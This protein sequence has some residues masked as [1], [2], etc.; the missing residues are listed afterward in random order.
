MTLA[1]AAT[2]SRSSPAAAARCALIISR[3]EGAGWPR[4][5]PRSGR[6]ASGNSPT[7]TCCGAWS[8][9]TPY[10]TARST[11]SRVRIS[12]A[13]GP[14]VRGSGVDEASA[15]MVD[16]A[17]VGELTS[18]SIW[19][20]AP[21]LSLHH[22]RSWKPRRRWRPGHQARRWWWRSTSTPSGA[23][24]PGSEAWDSGRR[25]AMSYDVP[26][27]TRGPSRGRGPDAAARSEGSRH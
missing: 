25:P 20:R 6:S 18:V 2:G 8:C 24:W 26:G 22:R 27:R 4:P 21:A 15:A 9:G 11:C 16:A 14:A 5:P 10:R 23:S 7:T 1:R 17:E 19:R 12:R 13:S 3:L